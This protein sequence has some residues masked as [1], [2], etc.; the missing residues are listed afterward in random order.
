MSGHL[1]QVIGPTRH[2]LKN[3]LEAANS[4]KYKK[5]VAIDPKVSHGENVLTMRQ[6]IFELKT[7]IERIRSAI[8]ILDIKNKE[9]GE[10]MQ[11]LVGDARLA[12]E[13]I[14]HTFTEG[15]GD[16]NFISISLAASDK[17]IQLEMQKE[18]LEY[19]LHNYETDSLTSRGDTKSEI[20][21]EASSESSDALATYRPPSQWEAPRSRVSSVPNFLSQNPGGNTTLNNGQ[22]LTPAKGSAPEMP[23]QTNTDVNNGQG[24]NPAPGIAPGMLRQRNNAVT[25]ADLNQGRNQMQSPAVL[26]R[27]K[28]PKI[29]L[30][31][32]F[33]EEA[34][35]KS[36][37]DIFEVAVHHQ[38]NL[39]DVEKF[40]YLQ[41]LLKGSAARLIDGLDLTNENYAV[42]ISMLLQ[43]FGKTRQ[44]KQS[45]YLKLEQLQCPSYKIVDQ[46]TTLEEVQRILRQ[47]TA[48]KEDINQPS[49]IRQVLHKFPLVTVTRI[50]E[51]RNSDADWTMDE[52][53]QFLNSAIS[54]RS[55]AIL[56]SGVSEGRMDKK[57]AMYNKGSATNFHK[58][59]GSK[60]HTGGNNT[61][62][63][64]TT[65]TANGSSNVGNK[66]NF[67]K[68]KNPCT[69]CDSLEH[70]SDKC[71]RFKTIHERTE[72][73]KNRNLCLICL[74]AGHNSSNCT[75]QSKLKP[76]YYC[77]SKTHKSAMCPLQFAPT[78]KANTN[79]KYGQKPQAKANLT[80]QK[81]QNGSR[82]V[83]SRQHASNFTTSNPNFV[84]PKNDAKGY[85]SDQGTLS[86]PCV[87]NK[88]LPTKTMLL[89]ANVTI[90]NP[91]N[92]NKSVTVR[93][94]LDSGSQNSFVS[95][96]VQKQLCIK[97]NFSQVL[98]VLTFGSEK[99]KQIPSDH[100]SFNIM[101]QNGIALQIGAYSIP[102]LTAKLKREAVCKQDLEVLSAYPEHYFADSVPETTDEF[103]PDLLLGLNCF[104]KIVQTDHQRILPSGLS[105]IPSQLG[106][107]LGGVNDLEE[108]RKSSNND[109]M[110]FHTIVN[111]MVGE[112]NVL[113]ES[114]TPFKVVPKMEDMW[115]LEQLGIQDDPKQSDD[116]I[117]LARFNKSIEFK[118][119]R[120]HLAWPWVTENPD[121]PDN[122]NL[123]YKRF[124][125]QVNKLAKD[126]TLLDGCHNV[127]QDQLK[128]E[129]IEP[130]NDESKVEGMLHYIPHQI[131]VTPG[132]TTKY[133][134]VFDASSKASRDL[135]SLNECLLRGPILL[136]DLAGTILRFRM[137]K[138]GMIADVCKAF[139]QMVLHEDQR[140][141]TR[142]YWLKSLEKKPLL[143]ETNVQ[144]Y[145][146]TRVLFGAKSS[147]SMLNL[148]INHH[149]SQ[150]KTELSTKILQ[151]M[152]VDNLICGYETTNEG[153]EFFLTGKQ[154]F[155]EAGMYLREWYTNNNEVLSSIPETDQAKQVE[156]LKVLGIFW[157]PKEDTLSIAPYKLKG[158]P[159]TKRKIVETVA[160]IFDPLGYFVP[161]TIGCKMLIQE[162][163][164]KKFSWDDKAPSE[165]QEKFKMMITSM[166]GFHE[167]KIPRYI[168]VANGL[169]KETTF[170]L[171][172]FT[173]G[174]SSAYGAVVYL[175]AKNNNKIESN[176]VMAKSRLIPMKGMTIPRTELMGVLVGVRLLK[177]VVEQLKVTIHSQI[178]WTDST[179]V[180]YW[181][182][183]SKKQ[184]MFVENRLTEIKKHRNTTF[185]YI[186]SEENPADFTTKPLTLE[187]FKNQ[188][189]FWFKGPSFLRKPKEN[190]PQYEKPEIT[191]ELIDQ[192][193]VEA[194][195]PKALPENAL[196]FAVAEENENF[197][198]MFLNRFSKLSSLLQ[199]TF[200]VLHFLKI[201]IW[202]KL[203]DASKLKYPKLNAIFKNS[204]TYYW[205]KVVQ[206]EAFGDIFEALKNKKANSMVKQMNLFLGKNGL[207]RLKGRLAESS[208]SYDAQH[209]I[210]MPNNHKF[211]ELLMKDRHE[212]LKHVGKE[213][214]LASLRQKYWIT[215]ARNAIKN[216]IKKCTKCKKYKGP[217]YKLPE[218]PNLPES[219]LLPCQPFQNTGID[220]FGP[221]TIK[222]HQVAT[223]IWGCIFVCFVT[224]AIHLEFVSNLSSIGFLNAL[225]RFIS[226]RGRPSQLLSDNATTFKGAEKAIHEAWKQAITHED[227]VSYCANEEIK[228]KFISELS[229]WKGG[230][231]ERLIG[232]VKIMLKQAIGRCQPKLEDFMTLLCE[233]E[234]IINS[235]PLSKISED[236]NDPFQ[237]LRPI[238][239]LH[240]TWSNWH[241][242]FGTKS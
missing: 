127:I 104:L 222:V 83:S 136:P 69:F 80:G 140:D 189:E 96:W 230:L 135:K 209:P 97:P 220:Y 29:E 150:Y 58:G 2:R 12:E 37:W 98:S 242:S 226:R 241:R 198:M 53:L 41:G 129:I 192:F 120:Y 122:K 149:L 137:N 81:G 79:N 153:K 105:L 156:K 171:M 146:F 199:C 92:P 16:N 85:E 167:I 124:R 132:K 190:W 100:L 133:R 60:F 196:V 43:R 106:L 188:Q 141:V 214:V 94:F 88:V 236:P 95:S 187:E 36:F 139:L 7:L 229:P 4:E 11:S 33:G 184:P 111:M 77:Q 202:S 108:K 118:K 86:S 169:R 89:T 145:K 193:E 71:D 144:V 93:A 125:T 52:L 62:N 168:C 203:S 134:I 22:G 110:Q 147:P 114:D 219:R 166:N 143:D 213:T 232:L 101:L 183:S 211:V 157:D 68:P 160:T 84:E 163:W 65:L 191:P 75:L 5:F 173:D 179:C 174:S 142:F 151:N 212:K 51:M 90:F 225:R 237:I 200:F 17:V 24:L 34:K 128:Q 8:N 15:A 25:P 227:T 112:I 47:L 194:K 175:I 238:D 78:N 19:T 50:E 63:A 59:K 35:F 164:R 1:R 221:I 70:F 32:F 28:L 172:C 186:K 182:S 161:V 216:V 99:A 177:F 74:K 217:P 235:R 176:M 158:T 119:G 215:H 115:S 103:Y 18:E 55:R 197:R 205:E 13:D 109:I 54:T 223:K 228:W 233:T 72:C 14:Y 155:K 170:E 113:S 64:T 165:L 44:S 26:S 48:I 121:L 231:Y 162:M 21:S 82:N 154:M 20:K 201:M 49:L 46:Q 204:V 207:I 224:R 87:S 102:C 116:D 42:A 66:G 185:K 181:I 57:T 61:Q 148:T 234:S 208:L 6:Q 27:I 126:K 73:A 38:T 130:V 206:K 23:M 117:A 30:K 91:N 76:C 39:A 3:L 159:D 56:S 240:P 123:A 9:W 178:L 10:F 67:F 107:L 31:P 45:L 152:Y 210:L 131:V 195:P 40:S 239:F 138:Y 180:L 218:M